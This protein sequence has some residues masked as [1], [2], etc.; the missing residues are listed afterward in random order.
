MLASIGFPRADLSEC[1]RLL[2]AEEVSRIPG[3][4]VRLEGS[5]YPET[6]R[7]RAFG[8]VNIGE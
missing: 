7:S 1:E 5:K 3:R 2:V 8:S 4:S 6:R